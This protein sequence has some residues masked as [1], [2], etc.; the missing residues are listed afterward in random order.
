[1]SISESDSYALMFFLLQTRLIISAGH[2]TYLPSRSV[3][4]EVVQ[5]VLLFSE[6]RYA[7]TVHTPIT[8]YCDGLLVLL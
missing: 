5:C 7:A 3:L 2:F 8:P 4:V 1:M 6:L